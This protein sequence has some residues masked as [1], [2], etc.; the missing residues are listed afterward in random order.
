MQLTQ[1]DNLDSNVLIEEDQRSVPYQSKEVHS[2]RFEGNAINFF[3]KTNKKK[4]RKI[5]RQSIS[6]NERNRFFFISIP[7]QSSDD[8]TS[9]CIHPDMGKGNKVK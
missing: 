3:D 7:E 2:F 8:R 1:L 4:K 5:T 9:Q 6:N